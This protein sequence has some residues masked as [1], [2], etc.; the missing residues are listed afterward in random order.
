MSSHKRVDDDLIKEAKRV[1][2]LNDLGGWTRPTATLY[3]HQWL[4]DSCFIAIGLCHI[5][6]KRAQDEIRS[7]LRGQWKNGMIPYIVFSD[8]KTYHAGPSLWQSEVS[9]NSPEAVKTS[10]FSQPPMV[11]EAVVRIGDKLPKKQRLA[12]Y[13]EVYPALARYHEWWYRERDPEDS[14]LVTCFHSWETGSDN[15]PPWMEVLHR[16]ALSPAL[17]LVDSSKQLLKF[18]ERFR[19][20]TSVVPANERM[21][22][23]DLMA[24]YDLVR[25]ARRMRYDGERLMKRH[26]LAIKDLTINSVLARA[27]SLL[28]G[29]AEEIGEALPER[30]QRA[31]KRGAAVLDALWDE[32]SGLYYNLDVR[33]GTLV[34]LG[35]HTSL[36]PLYAGK[37]PA[38]HVSALLKNLRDPQRFGTSYSVPSAPVNSPYFKQHCYW[39]GPVWINTNWLILQGLRRNGRAAEAE[40]IKDSSLSLV[41]QSGMSEYFSPLDGSPA[42]APNFSWTAALTL[43]LLHE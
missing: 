31:Y 3:P 25:S 41:R 40:K 36:L 10:G 28:A 6:V 20:D 17:R 7:L 4:W 43:D 5:D 22:T 26:K 29:I 18:L 37:L 35:A 21:S 9:A 2:K 38:K 14:G 12:W 32:K 24:F 39:Q 42:G 16:H 8:A 27:N 30:C 11:A 33:R 23:L 15:N 34:E 13:R 1:L 19:R